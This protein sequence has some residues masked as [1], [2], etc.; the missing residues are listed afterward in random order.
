MTS[1][2][3]RLFTILSILTLSCRPTEHKSHAEQPN[4]I[5]IMADDLGYGDLSCYGNEVYQ[6][7]HIDQLAAEG[8]R[9]TDYHSNG[10]V[11]SPTR[12]ALMTGRYQQRSGIGGVVTAAGHRHTGLDRGETTMAEVMKANG[13]ATA[14]F[15]KWHL[16]YDP[17]FN[18][19]RQGFDEF[20]GFVSGNVDYHSHID[21]TGIF[22]WW[23][24]DVL[25]DDEGYITDLITRYGLDFIDRHHQAPFFLY[26]AHGAPHYP[27]QGRDDRADRTVGGT[28]KNLGSREDVGQAYQEMMFALDEG[29]GAVREKVVNLGIAEHTI[30]IFI[31][32]NG[33]NAKGSNGALRGFK[34]TLWEGGHRVP[35][36][37]WWPGKIDKGQSS[38]S[39]LLSM[40][41]FPTILALSSINSGVDFD[42]VD[43]SR[44]LFGKEGP[45]DRM[46]CWRFK[47][48]KCA[49]SGH[50]KLLVHKQEQY[51][52]NLSQD[53][54]E[55]DNLIE[56]EKEVAD[57][58]FDAL[59]RWEAD[60]DKDV[61]KRT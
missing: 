44:L 7:P 28:F 14:L 23:K 40:D 12:A 11:C 49:R 8:M 36:L 3:L 56:S 4:I 54:G 22:D 34:G 25:L 6:T 2:G 57:R 31:S 51:L 5:L 30:I 24:Q 53:L 26:L 35:M 41:L 38:T 55:R 18:P 50:W 43:F 15:G 45:A 61:K 16:G 60:V 29:V 47:D 39:L 9:F 42:G 46:V 10:A 52:F 19:V 20:R 27:Y 32:D 1:I 58:L 59:L 17:Q 48:W 37:A 13:Y 33:A 21:Q